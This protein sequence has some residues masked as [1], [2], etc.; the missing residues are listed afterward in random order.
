MACKKT[1][2]DLC[3]VV[4]RR[5]WR[6]H[7]DPNFQIPG[8]D[9]RGRL[10]FFYHCAKSPLPVR[11]VLAKRKTEPHIEKCAENYCQECVQ[12]NIV[13][14]LKSDEKYLFLF[15]TCKCRNPSFYN[16]RFIVGYIR[17]DR[18]LLCMGHSKRWW[19]VQ[20]VTKL[21]SFENA[22]LLD[23]Y[24]GGPFYKVIRFKMLDADRTAKVLAKLGKGRNILGK[25]KA[26]I[27]RL[28]HSR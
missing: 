6:S 22:Y 13:G 19:S 7:E 8:T 5:R 16:Q 24:V 3:R 4:S 10:Q 18:A 20:G 23:R 12:K 26:E 15:T 1:P 28:V 11:D 2:V 25:C 14:F 27:E 17:K 9:K 21:V